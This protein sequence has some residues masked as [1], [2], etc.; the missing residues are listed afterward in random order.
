MAT[1]EEIKKANEG[2][3]TTDI[4]GKKY[5]EVN[6]RIKAFRMVYPNGSI[7]TDIE[8]LEGGYVLMKATASDG[9]RVLGTGYAYENQKASKI[10]STSFIENCETSAI[11]RALGMCGFGID[12][13]LASY[14]EV[15]NAI[16]QQESASNLQM[17][18]VNQIKM[19][20]DA[21]K[22]Q[23]GRLLEGLGLAKIED[24]SFDKAHEIIERLRNKK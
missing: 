20:Q 10:N 9:D 15:S 5:V 17:I 19:I 8:R 4:K 14:E 23:L 13:S 1:W 2:L 6:Q 16:Q 21:Y 11:G 12:S 3:K 7:S 18:T 24:M 22:D